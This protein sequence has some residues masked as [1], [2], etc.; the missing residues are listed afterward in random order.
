MLMT[1]RIKEAALKC[2]AEYGYEGASLSSIANVVGI[3]KPSIYA[4]FKGKDE[5]F[6]EVFQHALEHEIKF[7]Q[8][9][10]EEGQMTGLE[11]CLFEYIKQQ[12]Q[13]YEADIKAKFFLRMSFFP[14]NHLYEEMMADVYTYL[15]QIEALFYPLFEQ[16]KREGIVRT[17]VETEMVANAFM[18]VLDAIS[19]EMIYG[20]DK[21]AEKRINASWQIYWSGIT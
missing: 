5:L 1:E 14:P 6:L 20:G 4:H 18:G 19:I 10:I 21:R 7:A 11:W 17:E 12:K 15:D 3:K 8:A 9:F 16:A 2:F 13:R